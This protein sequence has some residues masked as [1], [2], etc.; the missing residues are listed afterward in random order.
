MAQGVRLFASAALLAGALGVGA[1]KPAPSTA[2]F[3]P[4]T[5]YI[6]LGNSASDVR[7]ANE[8][9]TAAVLLHRSADSF[10]SFDVAPLSRR[11]AVIIEKP[12]ST[13]RLILRTWTQ[14]PNGGAITVAPPRTLVEGD[15]LF[16]PDFSPDG[17]KVAFAQWTGAGSAYNLM[18]LD[19]ASGVASAVGVADQPFH[20]RW[21][22]TGDALYYAS[23]RQ[24]T[25]ETYT[26]AY[27]AYRQPITG[28]PPQQLFEKP[29][30]E[31]WDIL[32]DGTDGLILNYS[33]P[34]TGPTIP[35]AIWDGTSLAKVYPNLTGTYPHYTCQNTKLLYQSYS[36]TGN[37]G[38]YK[39]YTPAT[40]SDVIYTR[41]NNVR[42]ADWVPC[43]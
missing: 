26:S 11:S 23:H 22:A 25:G 29:N 6:Y 20:L 24:V 14:E 10:P 1:A 21:S 35:F 7:L 38:P 18:T 33:A 28:E 8:N 13:Y 41:D 30:I 40:E 43:G 9:G 3:V 5:A 12:G 4:A 32:R 16:Y 17:S 19:L 15:G 27:T 34:D 36:K 37:R 2:P 31:R 39:V 42:L